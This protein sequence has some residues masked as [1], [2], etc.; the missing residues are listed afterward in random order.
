MPKVNLLNRIIRQQNQKREAAKNSVW[1]IAKE[2]NNREYFVLKADKEG[3]TVVWIDNQ[4]KAM[5]FHTEKGCQH[6]AQTFLHNRSGV[7]L[8]WIEAKKR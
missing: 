6:F 1:I 2:Q 8:K 7:H 3:F 4:D 5:K